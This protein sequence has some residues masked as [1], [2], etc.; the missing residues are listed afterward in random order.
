MTSSTAATDNRMHRGT[1]M[2]E[3]QLNLLERQEYSSSNTSTNGLCR[4]QQQWM[5]LQHTAQQQQ[6][7]TNRIWSL[8]SSKSTNVDQLERTQSSISCTENLSGSSQHA[9]PDCN[10]LVV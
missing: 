1:Y 5:G 7:Q 6:Q 4:R 2:V 3:E 9:D 10:K 8:D